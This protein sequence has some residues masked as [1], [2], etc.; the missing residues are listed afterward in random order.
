MWSTFS[1]VRVAWRNDFDEEAALG[2]KRR[3]WM[4]CAQKFNSWDPVSE[5]CVGRILC[6]SP[7]WKV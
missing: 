6:S 7:V 2:L 1:G 5:S 4:S 3:L